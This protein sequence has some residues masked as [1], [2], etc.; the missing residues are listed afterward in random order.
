MFKINGYV[1]RISYDH[2]IIFKIIAIENDVAILEGFQK[3]LIATSP[4]TDLT[5]VDN[6]KLIE[7]TEE[8]RFRIKGIKKL[9]RHKL[10]MTGKILHID[11]DKDYLD[12]CLKLYEE[13]GFKNLGIY[14]YV[15]GEFYTFV[16]ENF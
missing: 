3:R 13:L 9:S 16:K 14:N 1:S 10:H 6:I 5:L 7:A 11:A 8:S 4:L 12:K 15:F 2:D